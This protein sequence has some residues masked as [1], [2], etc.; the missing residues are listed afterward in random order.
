MHEWWYAAFHATFPTHDGPRRGAK[1]EAARDVPSPNDDVVDVTRRSRSEGKT[2]E[3][4]SA[5][6]GRRGDH[7]RH[8]TQG[9]L[10]GRQM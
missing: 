7:R 2:R 3:P 1:D 4:R 5:A 9:H 6:V 10:T 8:G